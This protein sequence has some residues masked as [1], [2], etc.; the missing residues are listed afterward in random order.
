MTY[1]FE[2]DTWTVG[3]LPWRLTFTNLPSVSSTHKDWFIQ[4]L[5]RWQKFNQ[6]IA[7]LCKGEINIRDSW[8]IY[9]ESKEDVAMIMLMFA[10]YV[11]ECNYIG[12]FKVII[13]GAKN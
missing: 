13:D 7:P 4:T 6:Q 5:S 10:E 12:E 11:D 9:F 2:Y 8:T 3:H 1:V